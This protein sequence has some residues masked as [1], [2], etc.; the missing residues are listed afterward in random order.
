MVHLLHRPMP[1]WVEHLRDTLTNRFVIFSW[2]GG[3]GGGSCFVSVRYPI[4]SKRTKSN[5]Q[6][7][8]KIVITFTH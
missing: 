2:G 1:D 3:G 4:F 6:K 5:G 7:R 8:T